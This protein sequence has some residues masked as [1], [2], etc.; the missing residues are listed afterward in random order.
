MKKLFLSLAIMSLTLALSACGG[1]VVEDPICTSDQVLEDGV[2]VD[3]EQD[4]VIDEDAAVISGAVEVTL[5]IGDAFDELTGVTAIDEIDGDITS[6][7][8]V[9]SDLDLTTIGNYEI[10]YTVT[11]SDGNVSSVTRTIII[12]SVAGC[13]IHYQLIDGECVREDPEVI[14]IMH[15]AVSQIDP[16]HDDYSGT[17]RALKQEQIELIEEELNVDIVFEQYSPSAAW[18]PSRVTSIIQS[19]VSGDHLSDLYWVA[20]NWIQQLVVGD[21]IASVSPYMTEHGGNID[22][23][24]LDIGGYQG[25]NYGFGNGEVQIS[26]GL[27]YNAELVESLGVANPT[28]L[29]LSGDWDWSTF[30]TW[31]TSVQVQLSGQGDD[32]YALG[33]I[34]SY[35]AQNMIPLNGGSLINAQTGRVAFSQKPALDTY[36]FLSN[37]YSKGLFELSPQ[38]DAGSPEWMAGKVAMHPGELWFL[39]ASN[40][41]GSLPF[42]LGFVP[43][44]VADDFTGEYISPVNGV[45]LLVMATG[46]SPEKEELV[47]QVWNEIQL[48][49]TDEELASDYELILLTKFDESIYV[50]AYLEIYDKIYFD[51]IAAMS[52][53]AFAADSWN[54]NINSG[55]REGTSRTVVDQIKPIYEAALDDYLG[56]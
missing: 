37:L 11:D 54:I 14:T 12:I 48:W 1:S 43:F 47:F 41:W 49:K 46:M 52:I 34:L 20:S 23:S 4:V 24:Y 13:A 51:L 2:C 9:T 40:R 22:E 6:S 45:A 55:I 38:Y 29:Y 44:P 36:D 50:E 16:F 3:E 27:Y 15:G 17:E 8:V 19:S 42:E 26:Y 35:Y 21:A 5:T 30:E 25:E 10:T 7:I 53:S 33:G 28:E 32:M 31:A 56:E 18:G 39:T